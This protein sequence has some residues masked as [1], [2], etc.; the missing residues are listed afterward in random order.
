MSEGSKVSGRL[1]SAVLAEDLDNRKIMFF[2]PGAFVA[3]SFLAYL[4]FDLGYGLLITSFGASTA[5]L[6]GTPGGRLAR[7]RNVFFGH[8]VSSTIAY[9]LFL[10][11]GCTWFSVAMAVTASIAVMLVTDTFHPPGGATAVV[12]MTSA[13]TWEYILMPVA[14]GA[15][16]LIVVAEVSFWIYRRYAG[17]KGAAI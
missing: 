6:F 8:V 7:P 14:V 12:T 2:I 1:R 10:L 11:M 16:F 5:I 13:P 9:I 4:T 3:I 15:V 17:S